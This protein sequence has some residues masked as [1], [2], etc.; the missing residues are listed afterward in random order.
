MWKEEG[1]REGAL[2]GGRE[3]IMGAVWREDGSRDGVAWREEGRS[4]DVMWRE[5]GREGL[6]CERK[7][8]DAV[9]GEEQGQES[10][11]AEQG[12]SEGL[13]HASMKDGR[14]RM[15]W[16]TSRRWLVGLMHPKRSTSKGGEWQQCCGVMMIMAMQMSQK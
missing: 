7:D 15:Q 3:A 9:G 16:R 14:R 11:H 1:S 8:G 10:Q 4:G 13:L 2:L 12:C 5:E 6:L